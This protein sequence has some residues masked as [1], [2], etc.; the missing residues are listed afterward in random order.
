MVTYVLVYAVVMSVVMKK[1]QHYFSP[2][3]LLEDDN[4]EPAN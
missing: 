4:N 3:S 2:E 1:I